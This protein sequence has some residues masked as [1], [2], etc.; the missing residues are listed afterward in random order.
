HVLALDVAVIP[1]ALAKCAQTV[2]H[3]VRRSDVK[4]PD[5][6]HRRLLRARRQRPRD[7]RTTAKRDELAPPHSITSSARAMT[8]AG[9]CRP[10][11]FATLRLITSSNL[12]G[13]S[14]GRS[15]GFAPPRILAT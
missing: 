2:R 4:E 11:A 12:V 5:D 8:V 7:G 1:E 3:S 14:T 15:A 13:C 9:I 10:S 6:R